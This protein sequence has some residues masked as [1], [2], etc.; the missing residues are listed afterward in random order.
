MTDYLAILQAQGDH[1]ECDGTGGLVP[2][3]G[4]GP[5]MT[6]Q[7]TVAEV[8]GKFGTAR[9]TVDGNYGAGGRGFSVNG[10]NATLF[11][12]RVSQGCTG[13]TLLS[14]FLLQNVGQDQE[15][16]ASGRASQ[17]HNRS[18]YLCRCIH[19]LGAGDE[20]PILGLS[21]H[22]AG[23]GFSP[24]F[25]FFRP[26]SGAMPTSEWCLYGVSVDLGYD[27]GNG[28][29]RG[30]I[31]IQSDPSPHYGFNEVTPISSTNPLQASTL[32][33]LTFG[34]GASWSNQGVRGY[35]DHLDFY[36]NYAFEEKDFL[37]FWNNSL[38]R[39]FPLGYRSGAPAKY[40]LRK[41]LLQRYGGR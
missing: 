6:E 28:A 2:S 4:N 21:N 11:D 13:F 36:L 32:D 25:G 22:A 16:A 9:G 35:V 37:H 10:P 15:I 23:S 1:Y 39:V 18:Q 29:A 34:I 5:T 12:T 14:W 24:F 17:P 41:K 26:G 38:G 7:N 3:I 31:G 30:F 8:A 27:G 19:Q 33:V 20:A 40:I